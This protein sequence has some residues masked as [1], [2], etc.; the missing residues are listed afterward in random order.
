MPVPARRC[1]MEGRAAVVVLAVDL[2]PVRS[3][4]QLGHAPLAAAG[5]PRPPGQ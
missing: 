5:G 1:D 3:Q 4:E 2:D